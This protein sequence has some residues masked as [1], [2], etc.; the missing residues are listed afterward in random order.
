MS[1]LESL[2]ITLVICFV[3]FEV[4]E[5]VVLPLFWFAARGRQKPA[6]G[7]A[8]TTG[9]TGVVRRWAGNEGQIEI[10]GELWR[11]VSDG[12]LPIGC[13]V[14]VQSIEGLTLKVRLREMSPP[15]ASSGS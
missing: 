8:A 14:V 15:D 2:V 6:S 11:A 3:A 13:K 7:R 12:S 5:H 1:T 4:I 10:Q 9:K